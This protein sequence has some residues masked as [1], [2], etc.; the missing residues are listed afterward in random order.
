MPA[1]AR[2][3]FFFSMSFQISRIIVIMLFVALASFSYVP[4]PRVRA[5]V[6]TRDRQRAG[7]YGD[8]SCL[9]FPPGLGFAGRAS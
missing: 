7:P 6:K 8:R 9:A 5:E 4:P 3:K 2:G 1:A